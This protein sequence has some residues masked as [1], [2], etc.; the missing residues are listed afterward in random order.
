MHGPNCIVWAN[1]TPV[2]LEATFTTLRD[3]LFGPHG[4]LYIADGGCNSHGQ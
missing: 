2:S 4:H 1:L 3:I